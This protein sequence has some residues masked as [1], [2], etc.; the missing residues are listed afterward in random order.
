MGVHGEGG[1]GGWMNVEL[2]DRLGG[3][4]AI[5]NQKRETGRQKRR[6]AA[7]KQILGASQVTD[8]SLRSLHS[9]SSTIY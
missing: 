3:G 2:Y 8:E 4:W 5:R 6:T 7:S 1:R 9:Y